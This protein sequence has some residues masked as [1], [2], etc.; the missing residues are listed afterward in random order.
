MSPNNPDYYHTYSYKP[1]L[2]LV[3]STV[4]ILRRNWLDFSEYCVFLYLY[5]ATYVTQYDVGKKHVFL[6]EEQS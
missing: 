3:W 6:S 4:L 5:M 1:K 2:P